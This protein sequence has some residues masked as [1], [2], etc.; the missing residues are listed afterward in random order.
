VS[1]DDWKLATPPEYEDPAPRSDDLGDEI[2]PCGCE[3]S[4][5]LRAELERVKADFHNTVESWANAAPL[6]FHVSESRL[7]QATAL[8]QTWLAWAGGD[9]PEFDGEKMERA[10]DAFL[11]RAPAQPAAPEPS[12]DRFFGAIPDMPLEP[13]APE[14]SA[15]PPTAGCHDA[16]DYI[17]G[18]TDRQSAVRW[19]RQCLAAESQLA[20]V[21]DFECLKLDRKGF[22]CPCCQAVYERYMSAAFPAPGPGAGQE[23]GK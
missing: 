2:E 13:A 15:E 3:E 10:T 8:L 9:G 18:E 7:A 6:P 11:S 17:P 12:L 1:Y 4:E 14:P 21:K 5:A 23:G 20:A 16:I 22:A 19:M